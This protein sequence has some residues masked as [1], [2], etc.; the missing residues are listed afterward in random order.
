MNYRSSGV[1]IE[2]GNRA[3]DLI[4][5]SVAGTHNPLVLNNLGGFA[6]CYE[7]PKG[8]DEP[9]LVSCTDGVGT[10][11]QI[12]IEA[13]DLNTIGID[14]VAMCVN[15]LICTGATPLY[16]L[17]YIAC[18]TLKPPEIKALITGMVE[19]CKAAEC[20]L[21]GG[22]MAEMGNLY[23]P[24]DF[25]LAGFSVGVVEKRNIITG[26]KIQA[27]HKIY[28]L[29]SS[30]LHSNGFS[31]VRKVLPIADLEKHGLTATD[32]LTPTKIYVRSMLAFI[33][34]HPI[35]GI[36]HIT[37]GGLIE[38]I[39]RVLPDGLTAAITKSEI[40]TP[41]IFQTIQ[42]TGD[43]AE[44]EMWKVFNMGIGMVMI[45]EANLPES[46]DLILIGKVVKKH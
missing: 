3:V 12:A 37:G 23:Q 8:Y 44:D 13:G 6:S 19:G 27:G 10:K 43:V 4:K 46:D 34:E 42:E 33:K 21:T 16:F 7:L 35:D 29:P 1:N 40:P 32:L 24:G 14:L 22:E 31:L 38:N 11:L 36:A 20:A 45:T 2:A 15:D 9:V 5:D 18:N 30:G 17:D 41:K 28:G 26:K 25:D 39:S